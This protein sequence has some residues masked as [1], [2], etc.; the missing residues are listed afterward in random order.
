MAIAL[1]SSTVVKEV[2]M[3]HNRRNGLGLTLASMLLISAWVASAAAARTAV[4]L[5][6]AHEGSAEAAGYH[7]VKGPQSGSLVLLG[8]GL[9]LAGQVLKRRKPRVTE[10]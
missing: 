10:D 7:T 4:S 3:A 8:T 1:L 6:K 5:A 9:A 2:D